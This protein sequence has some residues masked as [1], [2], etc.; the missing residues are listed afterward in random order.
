MAGASPAQW[1][2]ANTAR[3][4]LLT[5][6]LPASV[7]LA[8]VHVFNATSMLVRLAHLYEVGE[9]AALSKDVTLSLASLFGPDAAYKITAAVETTMIGTKPLTAVTP[10]TYYRE[11]GAHVT[12]PIIPAA[13]AGSGLDITLSVQQIRTFLLT[14]T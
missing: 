4:S 3:A 5:T 11:G 12:L 2:A 9:D 1:I 10:T 7:H 13:P 8:T 6:P 14:V